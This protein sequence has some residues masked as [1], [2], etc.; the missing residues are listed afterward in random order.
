MLTAAAHPRWSGDGSR[1]IDIAI[2]KDSYLS[3]YTIYY[4]AYTMSGQP[5]FFASL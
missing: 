5:I 3:S 4:E 2:F 1:I